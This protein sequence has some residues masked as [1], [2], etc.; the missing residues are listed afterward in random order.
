MSVF[1]MPKDIIDDLH[2]FYA[3]L[4]WGHSNGHASKHLIKWDKLCDAKDCGGMNFRHIEVFNEALLAKQAWR[5]WRED[6][7]ILSVVYKAKYYS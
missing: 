3:N 7:Q 6:N 1:K 5:L 4:W 2:R